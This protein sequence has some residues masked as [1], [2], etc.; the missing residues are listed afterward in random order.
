MKSGT[1]ALFI[2]SQIDRVRISQQAPVIS[3]KIIIANSRR[4]L[5]PRTV[6]ASQL[7][8]APAG[9][10]SGNPNANVPVATVTEALAKTSLET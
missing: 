6:M 2:S 3:P 7:P 8:L 1:G 4:R 9:V 10:L 5:L